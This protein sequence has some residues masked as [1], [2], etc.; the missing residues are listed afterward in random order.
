M[1]D[2][3]DQSAAVG[4]AA[5]ACGI[6]AHAIEDVHRVT[7]LQQGLWLTSQRKKHAYNYELV[8]EVGGK[9]AA[10]RLLAA[11]KRLV[12]ITPMLRSCLVEIA[13]ESGR[14]RARAKHHQLVQVILDNSYL[15]S[16]NIVDYTTS[17]A[18]RKLAAL[19]MAQFR[20]DIE[21]PTL[22]ESERLTTEDSIKM[23][24]TLHHALF[25]GWAMRLVLQ[26]LKKCWLGEPITPPPPFR[27]FIE[28]LDDYAAKSGEKARNFWHNMLSGSSP[29]EI[30]VCPAGH[31]PVTDAT[32][33]FV[34]ERPLFSQGRDRESDWA[35][36]ATTIT[37]AT[38][39]QTAFALLLGAYSATDDVLFGLITSGRD[40]TVPGVLD[41]AGPTM[42]AIPSRVIMDRDL[43]VEELLEKIARDSQASLPYQHSGISQI[44]RDFA[45]MTSLPQVLLVVQ[46]SDVDVVGFGADL[47]NGHTDGADHHDTSGVAW[48][49]VSHVDRVHP[50]ALVVECWIPR[51]RPG[52]D[53]SRL[54]LV[55]HYDARLFTRT[56]LGRLLEQLSHVIMT[57]NAHLEERKRSHTV[58]RVGD[59]AMVSPGDISLLRKLN[60]TIPPPV[61]RCLHQ[62]F[63]D[64]LRTHANAIAVDGWD[65]KF[66]YATVDEL[67]NSLAQ[68]LMSR[69]VEAESRVLVLSRK[70]AWVVVA[71]LAIS[72]AGGAFVSLEPA[73]PDSRLRDVARISGARVA[74][75]EPSLARRLSNLVPSE[76][77]IDVLD[78]TDTGLAEMQ[79]DAHDTA[80]KRF[81]RVSPSNLAYIIFTS[82]TTGVPKGV[83]AQHRAVCSSITA[84]RGPADMNMTPASR[85][86]HFSPYCFDAKIDEIFMTLSSG[87]CVCVAREDELHDD[88]CGVINRYAITWAFLTPS[89]ARTIDPK[90][91]AASGMLQTLSLGGEAV[92]PNDI[93]QWRGNVPQLCNGYGPTEC[94]VIC[95]VGDLLNGHDGPTLHEGYSYLGKPRGCIAWVVDPK[96]PSRLSPLGAAGELLIEGPNLAR[97][98]LGNPHATSAKWTKISEFTTQ[99]GTESLEYD[100]DRRAYRTGDLVR[101]QPDGSLLYLGRVEGDSQAKLRGQRFE[102]SEV[103]S[104]VLSPQAL[105][106]QGVREVAAFV[107]NR[108]STGTRGQDESQFSDAVNATCNTRALALAFVLDECETEIRNTTALGVAA[109]SMRASDRTDMQATQVLPLSAALR[110]QLRLVCRIL[111][112]T[113]PAY[114]IPT[115]WVP[116]SKMP[117]TPSTKMDRQ[118]LA[119]LMQ[120]F[121]ADELAVF[122]ADYDTSVGYKAATTPTEK[123][124]VRLCGSVLD[125]DPGKISVSEDFL[126]L[127]G[128]SI[129]AMRLAAS[130]RSEG[131][132]LTT[133]AV[134]RLRTIEALAKHHGREGG[135]LDKS[136]QGSL[137]GET[138]SSSAHPT[139]PSAFSLL[140]DLDVPK[141]QTILAAVDSLGVDPSSIQDVY[142]A[143]PLQRSL[144]AL[145]SIHKDSYRGLF[146]FD[147]PR[148]VDLDLV[149]R[150]WA[151][152]KA[153]TPIIRTRLFMFRSTM[154]QAVVQ[155]D[156]TP[157]RIITSGS[158][159]THLENQHIVSREVTFGSELFSA[160][161]V[162]VDNNR[163]PRRNHFVLDV[164][165][166]VYDG[167]SVESIMAEMER[168]CNDNARLSRD[169]CERN[170]YSQFVSHTVHVDPKSSR[171]FWREYFSD[172][173]NT[174][175]KFPEV[176][177]DANRHRQGALTDSTIETKSILPD[178]S[179]TSSVVIYAAWSQ[180]AAAYGS[181]ED[182]VFGVTSHGRDIPTLSYSWD[183]VGPT[184]ATFP[185]RVQVPSGSSEA[186]VHDF[187]KTVEERVTTIT[188][189]GFE[190][191]GI[192]EI[193]KAAAGES[194]GTAAVCAFHSLVIVQAPRERE[195]RKLTFGPARDF[196][197][198]THPYPLVLEATPLLDEG[199]LHITAHY[200]SSLL[201]KES[202]RRLM[203]Q[204]EHL[205]QETARLARPGSDAKLGDVNLL[206]AADAS[207]IFE[208]WNSSSA[209][210]PKVDSCVHDLIAARADEHPSDPAICSWDLS[211]SYAELQRL[212]GG[213]AAAL[214]REGV[215]VGQF[216][217]ICVERSAWS[218]VSQIAVLKAGGACIMLDPR[219]PK[220]RNEDV[221]VQ[222]RAKLAIVSD[223]TKGLFA[224]SR[225][226]HATIVA[227]EVLQQ[228]SA[229]HAFSISSNASTTTGEGLVRPSDAAYCV[230]TSGSTGSPKGIVID[231]TALCTSA[232]NYG[233]VLGL[234]PSSRVLHFASSTF[235]V[236]LGEVLSPLIHGGCVCIPKEDDRLND[237]PGCIDSFRANWV[238]LTASVAALVRPEDPRVSWLKTLVVGGEAVQQQVV[239]TWA[240]RNVTLIN[241]YGPAETTIYCSSR[242]VPTKDTDARD[243]GKAMGCRMWIVSPGDHRR[244]LPI[245]ATGEIVVDGPILARGY[246][247]QPDMTAARFLTSLPFLPEGH[248]AYCTGDLACYDAGGSF[249]FRGRSDTQIKVNGQRVDVVEVETQIMRLQASCGVQHAAVV[250]FQRQYQNSRTGAVA[251]ESSLSVELAAFICYDNFEA[252][253]VATTEGN[254]E[255]GRAN[256]STRILPLTEHI[257]ARVFRVKDHLQTLLPAYMLPDV[258]LPVSGLP[259]TT[260]SKVDRKALERTVESL[261]DAEL[262]V[263]S[264]LSMPPRPDPV[265]NGSVLIR[266]ETISSSI[267]QDALES[268]LEYIWKQ[269][270][271]RSGSDP[272]ES[273]RTYTGETFFA[274][275]GNSLS[276]MQMVWQARSQ[277]L[278]LSVSDL[279][280]NPTIPQLAQ[281]IR[282]RARGKGGN[283]PMAPVNE[284]LDSTPE[285]FSLV[286]SEE[287]AAVELEAT[288]RLGIPAD[289]IDDMYP[290][291]DT[292]ISLLLQT[293]QRARLWVAH[294]QWELP[295][296]L[297][298]DRFRAAWDTVV[299]RCPILRTR[300]LQIDS[301]PT[302]KPKAYQVVLRSGF[303]PSTTSDGD[304]SDC[305]V[306]GFGKPLSI[307]RILAGSCRDPTGP[308]LFK[309][310]RHHVIYDEWSTR[311]ILG[312]VADIYDGRTPRETR[313]FSAYVRALQNLD[314]T[315]A[316]AF[317]LSELAGVGAE[318]LQASRFPYGS[319]AD[320]SRSP[321]VSEPA[322]QSLMRR[323]SKLCGFGDGPSSTMSGVPVG[324]STVLETAW[325]FVISAYTGSQDVLFGVVQSGRVSDVEPSILHTVGPTMTMVP[326]RARLD[327][328]VDI[329]TFL[330][331]YQQRVQSAVPYEASGLEVMRKVLAG[332]HASLNNLLVIQAGIGATIHHDEAVGDDGL[333]SLG[334]LP[335]TTGPVSA[336]AIA[337]PFGLVLECVMPSLSSGHLELV[338]FYDQVCIE[339]DT[340]D[341][342]L[343]HFEHVVDQLCRLP[344]ETVVGDVSIWGIP[345]QLRLAHDNPPPAAVEARVHDLIGRHWHADSHLVDRPA[346]LMRSTGD[347][348]GGVQSHPTLTYRDL[349]RYSSIICNR[350]TQGADIRLESAEKDSPRPPFVAICLEKS[351]WTVAVML[352]VW[353]AGAAVVLLDPGLPRYHLRK[354]VQKVN[355]ILVVV[356]SATQHLWEDSPANDTDGPNVKSVLMTFPPEEC[357]L[358]CEEALLRLSRPRDACYCVFTSG[359]TGQPKGVVIQHRS[360][361][362]SAV[363]H[364]RE[365]GLDHASR[366]LQFASYSFDV[367]IDEIVTTLIHGGCVC[368]VG[369][370]DRRS[371][372]DLAEAMR[373]MDVGVA[374]LTPAVLQTLDPD[375]V[376]ACL[377]TVVVG[378]SPLSSS[379]SALWEGRLRLLM[380]YGPSECSVTAT[381]NF[382]VSNTPPG[383][384]GRPVGCRT[385][386]LGPDPGPSDEAVPEQSRSRPMRLGPLGCLG[387]LVIEGP[388]LAE[389]YAGDPELTAKRFILSS[390]LAGEFC[391]AT[392]C[393][394]ETRLY[395]TGDLVRQNSDGSLLF[396]GRMDSQVKV[397][398]VSVEVEA[399]EHHILENVGVRGAVVVYPET[400]PFSGRLVAVVQLKERGD[401]VESSPSSSTSA[402][403]FE[404]QINLVPDYLLEAVK[405]HVKE[406]LPPS[407]V[408]AIWVAISRMPLLP[409][410]K[411]NRAALCKQVEG[412]KDIP[413]PHHDLGHLDVSPLPR[414]PFGA[415]RSEDQRALMPTTSLE[416]R[417]R[418]LMGQ[419]LGAD[420]SLAPSTS[421]FVRLGG[422]SLLAMQLVSC[423][424]RAGL[425]G[426]SVS[427]LLMDTS[428]AELVQVVEAAA[429]E[430]ESQTSSS[431][432]RRT[433]TAPVAPEITEDPETVYTQH[434]IAL[435]FAQRMFFTHYP[436]GP[437]YFNQSV[438]VFICNHRPASLPPVGRDEVRR[439][440]LSLVKRHDALRSR[441]WRRRTRKPDGTGAWF[442]ESVVTDDVV[443]SLRFRTHALDDSE[444]CGTVDVAQVAIETHQ[445]LNISSGPLFAADLFFLPDGSMELLLVAHHLVVDIVS[446]SILLGDLEA[447]ILGTELGP[448]PATPA[449]EPGVPSETGGGEQH[450]DI[451]GAAGNEE[452]TL[453]FWGMDT[454]A[455]SFGS[456]SLADPR[457]IKFSL[458]VRRNASRL[459]SEAVA[460][461]GQLEMGDV[462]E[463]V[464]ATVFAKFCRDR[465]R[466]SPLL[467]YAEDHGR[468]LFHQGREDSGSERVGWLTRLRPVNISLS[469][470]HT[471]LLE[472]IW[473]ARSCRRRSRGVAPGVTT[474]IPPLPLELV[475]NYTG[476]PPI[477]GAA[478]SSAF[479]PGP[480]QPASTTTAAELAT[481]PDT[482]P[483][484]KPLA[485]I[486]V[487]AVLHDKEGMELTVTY[488]S[489]LQHGGMLRSCLASCV[490]VLRDGAASASGWHSSLRLM[491]G[492][493]DETVDYTTSRE[494][495]DQVMRKL[496]LENLDEIETI[497][498]CSTPQ[499]QILLAQARARARVPSSLVY[500]VRSVWKVSLSENDGRGPRPTLDLARLHD[501]CEAVVRHH[502]SLRTVFVQLPD[503][504]NPVQVVLRDARTD[505]VLRVSSGEDARSAAT[506]ARLQLDIN[507]AAFDGSSTAVLLR[508]IASAY[509]GE[510]LDPNGASAALRYFEHMEQAQG[511]VQMADAFW[512]QHLQDVEPCHLPQLGSAS[513]SDKHGD[514]ES[515]LGSFN[516]N[517]DLKGAKSSSL[518]SWC[519]RFG[520]TPAV[521]IHTAWA[522]ALRSYCYTDTEAHDICFG[523]I[524]SGRDLPV[525]GLEN[526]VGM[527][528][529]ILVCRAQIS[530]H[531]L[532]RDA[533]A[534][535]VREMTQ[536][537]EHQTGRPKLH[538]HGAPLFDTLVTMQPTS[539]SRESPDNG[540]LRFQQTEGF[541]RTAYALCLNVGLARDDDY[542]A[543]CC[544]TYD[545][546]R[547]SETAARTFFAVFRQALTAITATT[548]D[549]AA[550]MADVDLF[551]PS[552]LQLVREFN[553][554]DN[555][556]HETEK[557]LQNAGKNGASGEPSASS[558][559]APTVVSLFSEQIR[560]HPHAVAVEAWDA[561][562]TFAQLDA[563]STSLA[564]NL[565]DCL[566]LRPGENVAL[567]CGKSAWVVVAMLAVLRAGGAC[568]LLSPDDGFHRLHNMAVE[569]MHA[570]V[571]IASPVH[572]K[573][574]RAL[575]RDSDDHSSS[576]VV[577]DPNSDLFR[578]T[579]C[580]R[581]IAFLDLCRPGDVA[582][583]VFTS[584]STG[585]PK[586]IRLA[587]S[588]LCL[589]VLNYTRHLGI[590]DKTR[591]FQFSAYTFD[592]GVGDVIASLV[593]G[594]VLCVP[595][596]QDRLGDLNGAI[597]RFQAS[598]VMLTPSVAA[599]LRPERIKN[600]SLRTI[601]LIGEVATSELYRTW[602]GRVRLF[603]AYG[604]AECSV[605]S[606][607]REVASPEEKPAI[608]GAAVAPHCRVWV[609]DAADS[610]RMVP[611]G[612]VGE[613]LIEGQHVALGYLN[614]PDK[615]SRAF[616]SDAKAP[617]AIRP[618]LPGAGL[619]LTGDLARLVPHQGLVFLGRKDFQIKLRGQRVEIGEIEFHVHCRASEGLSNLRHSAV[620][621]SPGGDSDHPVGVTAA[622]VAITQASG[623]DALAAFVS[624]TPGRHKKIEDV[625][626]DGDGDVYS[627]MDEEFFARIRSQLSL[628]L[629][630]Y[631]VPSMFLPIKRLPQTP[632]GKLDRKKLQQ[633]AVKHCPHSRS[634]PN[635]PASQ[636][637]VVTQTTTQT[638]SA[639]EA[640][641]R[642]LSRNAEERQ[643]QQSQALENTLTPS[644]RCLQSLW[645]EVLKVEAADIG[646]RDNFFSCGGDSILAM[647]LAAAALER[648]IRLPVLTIMRF[649]V[650]SRM[651]AELDRTQCAGGAGHDTGDLR[652]GGP[653]RSGNTQA[654]PGNTREVDVVSGLRPQPQ[655]LDVQ[656]EFPA[657]SFQEAVLTF[658]MAPCRGFLNYFVLKLDPR[659]DSTRLEAACCSLLTQHPVL[660]SSFVYREDR[661][662]QRIR[663]LRAVNFHTLDVGPVDDSEGPNTVDVHVA[664]LIESD[665]NTP[666]AWGDCLTKVFIIRHRGT[667]ALRLI[668]RLSHALYDGM[669]LSALWDD[670]SS[671]Y[672]DGRRPEANIGEQDLDY[673][674]FRFAFAVATD[675]PEAA[676]KFWHG[677]LDGSDITPVVRQAGQQ[678]ASTLSHPPPSMRLMEG[679]RVATVS[680]RDL[681]MPSVTPA[682]VLKAAWA[683]V[684][685]T[686]SHPARRDV[687][688]GH[689]TSCR[690]TL[691]PSMQDTVGAFVNCIP[692][693]VDVAGSAAGAACTT[694]RSTFQRLVEQVQAQHVA[695][696]PHHG[697]GLGQLIRSGTVTWK[698]AR[699]HS[700]VQ[701]QNLPVS[702]AGG[703]SVIGSGPLKGTDIEVD[704]RSGAYAN[705]WVT[706]SPV[707]AETTE[708]ELRYDASVVED[709]VARTLLEALC[710]VLRGMC[711][712]NNSVKPA[713]A[714]MK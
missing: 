22:T 511:Q 118:R 565:I 441:F 545:A 48:R 653:S 261:S 544:I 141:P 559:S 41:M 258:Y 371:P 660:R 714:S 446:W 552:H 425:P 626:G 362:T 227:S 65:A 76:Y 560:T 288:R 597:D 618:L 556:A 135:S 599:L 668:L 506:F 112:A 191:Y 417:V 503:M 311:L 617:A 332:G 370:E 368:V 278:D 342:L 195:P 286:T 480:L 575:L 482:D 1:S 298:I 178:S 16:E 181:S 697:V 50:Y 160:H 700:V 607:I 244:L 678:D 319:T 513:R 685:A 688:F 672:N 47:K 302:S 383:T 140:E 456:V 127:G 619:Y 274:L 396:V 415:P 265:S 172:T 173:Q 105:G 182:V 498:A 680:P 574:A 209:L 268:E 272:E 604:P 104:H 701:Y 180:L 529:N 474:S 673:G 373:E 6:P 702:A 239:E 592:V 218:A 354:A 650:L 226:L 320:L 186:L 193:G 374:L 657:T 645:A 336:D 358:P 589:S 184:I 338:A 610:S 347:G 457:S 558:A 62:L 164:H 283:P 327:D 215:Q 109:T 177:S 44:C 90:S 106:K 242:V 192:D 134:L 390:S 389:G 2:S 447:L 640:S 251:R 569:Q 501:A 689:V 542:T 75:V 554:S 584:G 541:D 159:E 601:V 711:A 69:G 36:T 439:H 111:S 289:G 429:A 294:D 452:A 348:G 71:L 537:L 57:L 157:C 684:L 365:M 83:E 706:A 583:V 301:G 455:S 621:T 585:K 693:R 384:I 339:K 28:Y 632:S 408:P 207:T 379:L 547:V 183:I 387:E 14:G 243:V 316:R 300:V 122:A 641:T 86:L 53:S 608:I 475:I 201:T 315:A 635:P 614:D 199:E 521:A 577:L 19:G 34:S 179:F 238:Y 538:S 445:S 235:D 514:I 609:V 64:S 704:G 271:G 55:A 123:K 431:M 682:S 58:T 555:L 432:M 517:L 683:V 152:V 669:C 119:Q 369:E 266:N 161:I 492:L 400:G 435:T 598:C 196:G 459:L 473:H 540:R 571:I 512:P 9:G 275:G 427:K 470:P 423:A 18:A 11:W 568:A 345:S 240:E 527:F 448:K 208:S 478:V 60:E 504:A 163:E 466:K 254:P 677:L 346:V 225:A 72:K 293:E 255:P 580:I 586:G 385:W 200:D 603:N 488:D 676:R 634:Q 337:F 666:L 363:H 59:I 616:I 675:M 21:P 5:A 428:I 35:T 20:I 355:V 398:G 709:E 380:A 30:V 493:G 273:E 528:A 674:F 110:S 644:Q 649:P 114:M 407:H 409:S 510:T 217:V 464:V 156:D 310:T 175:A 236:S 613:L 487:L 533:V 116:I 519:R 74:L 17:D 413:I 611:V 136:P 548:S 395:R 587:H 523:W 81:P 281:I 546:I 625:D 84:R 4:A 366:V 515:A 418:E 551:P 419:V 606:T 63:A 198:N 277:K 46:S 434:S 39:V 25:D 652:P 664:G 588:S 671:A 231:H 262:R 142:P 450:A 52:S 382:D 377:K 304:E 216:V 629:P 376:P 13:L 699:F 92:L 557:S 658:N 388:I 197:A 290:A 561:S 505:A 615:T 295:M 93:E 138:A 15:G 125:I 351:H 228:E 698:H 174:F 483:C 343:S 352:G 221:I 147:I 292:Q 436:F 579:A 477:R 484:L 264:A 378:G 460:S 662:F 331:S 279:Y 646:P 146:A 694:T 85:V 126:G 341:S 306:M 713:L 246:L 89:V 49:V 686:R 461:I 391:Q 291:T 509:A 79:H 167:W 33:S 440:L 582:F 256:S 526:A 313:P 364:G 467:V 154:W 54:R 596:E 202:V 102:L 323:K 51:R 639:L 297:D 318:A 567:L 133:A 27:R 170:D 263:L 442:W 444:R 361:C 203:G 257:S 204:L 654:S 667:G 107:F 695:G 185:L 241:A 353:R 245:G 534:A 573:T 42:A 406:R 449:L 524:S 32:A 321:V 95:V 403:A 309:W 593:T 520:A 522:L 10:Y 670:L 128:D 282:A 330:R 124:L 416:D 468:N 516:E 421:T 703:L 532:L 481:V 232:S 622:V 121:F 324:T 518:S 495:R 665:R 392:G 137:N 535:M 3:G 453:K 663:Q 595:C 219:H 500:Q 267:P 158:L 438:S 472:A 234:G 299:E 576:I 712:E 120:G 169:Y 43:P 210:P 162:V 78:M 630:P 153:A 151:A 410:G 602:H 411:V 26:E 206:S 594:A 397:R 651:A 80:C 334:L 525:R 553:N 340:V 247:N 502:P 176:Q 144:F 360:I 31:E 356:S 357:R 486:E 222:S 499:T 260:S 171:D 562:F 564:H 73:H 248:R 691:P 655:R 479:C 148:D 476:K 68:R 404:P 412:A 166:A 139:L 37:T 259:R 426:I 88:L 237:L 101:M 189:K 581:A 550:T 497:R 643:Q 437:G 115:Y 451:P 637:L 205:I 661:L 91:V 638:C 45:G 578:H 507:H 490:Q 230:F 113:L 220:A 165:H 531:T 70:S 322:T 329:G 620:H 150:A 296:D 214:T 465:G 401:D 424:R 433:P 103:E 29:T 458:S 623:E 117:L 61:E 491:P 56:Q 570:K 605:I 679:R 349:D 710:T 402:A 233:P 287:K 549:S 326:R 188:A 99:L 508:D 24:L 328:Q 443:G 471:S 612:C 420:L 250:P 305:P 98:Y 708:I 149:Q 213:L 223:A 303:E 705:V 642:G 344:P 333:A 276:A 469:E 359:S 187:V 97:G 627:R 572:E 130:C 563:L 628:D 494:R 539:A 496:G 77:K 211:L 23:I 405:G 543:E 393:R 648:G 269:V 7:P 131:I 40:S 375:G 284:N 372:A 108:R 194:S 350:L 636:G 600:D 462:V 224:D 489:R 317:W 96:N 463:A 229:P 145:G 100:S 386:I 566:G 485:L 399:I 253:S 66:T 335:V 659:V 591:L 252:P 690:E 270:L 308:S 249:H 87:A 129:T 367:A 394:P 67:S 314:K 312:L 536:G 94:C 633:L 381:M 143:T 285:P 696:L 631:M 307:H 325:A 168:A 656:N 132:Y 590:S 212:A 454:N 692:V 155:D 8:M 530:P 681:A 624:L 38:V 707:D 12:E 422:D 414:T 190:H 687:V 280:S 430:L 647:R 82:G